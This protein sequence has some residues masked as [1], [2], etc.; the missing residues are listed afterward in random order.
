[1]P[2]QG[3]STGVAIEDSILLAHVLSRR[4]SR[5]VAQMFADYEALRR[6][7][8]NKM[9]ESTVFRWKD[10]GEK[11]PIKALVMEWITWLYLMWMNRQQEDHFGRDVR[12]L[13]LPA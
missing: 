11:G 3:E 13:E 6:D 2:P 1:M 10:S 7:E 8:I 5:S 9:Y 4:E 12:K